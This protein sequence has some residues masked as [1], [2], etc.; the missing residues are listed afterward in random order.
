MDHPPAKHELD[1]QHM[2]RFNYTGP[3]EPYRDS[4]TAR[5][6]HA[7]TESTDRLI[8]TESLD[9]KHSRSLSRESHESRGRSPSPA[10][11]KPPSYGV[12]L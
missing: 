8:A 4:I 6:R 9:L 10:G 11:E 12:A 7:R 3:Y 1:D 5:S 2:S